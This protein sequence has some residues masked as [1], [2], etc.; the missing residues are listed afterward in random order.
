M[1][2]DLFNFKQKCTCN[3]DNFCIALK[4]FLARVKTFEKK[5]K[6]RSQ[7][8]IRICFCY[9]NYWVELREKL[10]LSGILLVYA[11]A[12]PLFWTIHHQFRS[13]RIHNIFHGFKIHNFAMNNFVMVIIFVNNR[14]IW[15]GHFFASAQYRSKGSFNCRNHFWKKLLRKTLNRV[16]TSMGVPY[17]CLKIL[18]FFQHL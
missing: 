13:F 2:W 3:I 17:N 1:D 18:K 16:F 10:D 4:L 6:K 8:Y 9:K 12:H 15:H 5:K 14:I 7:F 11:K